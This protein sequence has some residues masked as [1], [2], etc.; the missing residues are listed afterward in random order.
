MLCQ[1]A[2]R[3]RQQLEMGILGQRSQPL[4][5]L[6]GS[7]QFERLQR[8]LAG[9]HC[10]HRFNELPGLLESA[11]HA[12]HAEWTDRVRGVSGQPHAVASKRL[13]NRGFEVDDATPVKLARDGLFRSSRSQQSRQK[14]EIRTCVLIARKLKTATCSTGY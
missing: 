12:L 2:R 1:P 4:P 14:R 8:M 3:L 10:G 7:Q 6:C 13:C 11:I 5:A 9:A